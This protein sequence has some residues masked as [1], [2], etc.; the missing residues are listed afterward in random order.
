MH[1]KLHVH[2]LTVNPLVTGKLSKA[3]TEKYL[4]APDPLKIKDN[5]LMTDSLTELKLPSSWVPFYYDKKII[6]KKTT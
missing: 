4:N 6:R 3:A 5:W 1:Q 2:E